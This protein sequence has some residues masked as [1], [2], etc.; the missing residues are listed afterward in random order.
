MV[1]DSFS[2]YCTTIVMFCLYSI[3]FLFLLE[4]IYDLFLAIML[5]VFVR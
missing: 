4:I 5:V 1:L 3:K 2:F